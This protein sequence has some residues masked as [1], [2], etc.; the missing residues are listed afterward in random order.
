MDFRN[1][2][3]D[4]YGGLF[5][6]AGDEYSSGANFARK[7]GWYTSFYALAQ[8]DPTKFENV[9]RLS[10]HTAMMYLEFE[11]EKIELEQQMLKKK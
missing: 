9:A 8:G 11:K 4:S 2:I 10:L 5:G 7:W 6:G 3:V 1:G